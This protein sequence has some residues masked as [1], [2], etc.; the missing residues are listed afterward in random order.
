MPPL[1]LAVAGRQSAKKC[2]VVL[3]SRM[4]HGM[5]HIWA[6]YVVVVKKEARCAYSSQGVEYRSVVEWNTRK[7]GEGRAASC[8]N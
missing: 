4:D 3:A 7:G 6:Y 8:D 5:D 1:Q 2:Q